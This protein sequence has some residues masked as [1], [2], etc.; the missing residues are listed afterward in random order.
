MTEQ[1]TFAR[2]FWAVYLAL[3]AVIATLALGTGFIQA[4]RDY[5]QFERQ[6]QQVAP[7]QPSYLPKNYQSARPR[8]TQQQSDAL[9]R[10]KWEDAQ[11]D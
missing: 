3:L 11:V 7:S 1:L 8:P 6:M 2:I 10:Q 4:I 5:E 9:N